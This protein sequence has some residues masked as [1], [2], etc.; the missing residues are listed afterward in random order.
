MITVLTKQEVKEHNKELI[1]WLE[2]ALKSKQ[3]HNIYNVIL[4]LRSLIDERV[5]ERN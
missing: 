4:M 5:E 1:K 3:R 2:K